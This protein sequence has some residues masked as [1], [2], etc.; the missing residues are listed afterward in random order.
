VAAQARGCDAVVLGC[1]EI[2][3]LISERDSGL[4]SIDSTR[5][6]ARAALREAAIRLL[7]SR[8]DDARVRTL[9]DVRREPQDV[10]RDRR[11]SHDPELSARALPALW[12]KVE[13]DYSRPLI[14]LRTN[15]RR[16]SDTGRGS[17]GRG[18]HED[19]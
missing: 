16:V 6:L 12:G 3:L 1:T 8:N 19:S 17:T 13:C 10:V 11:L 15:E 18:V 5:T 2:P 14:L 9:L 4:P 7:D